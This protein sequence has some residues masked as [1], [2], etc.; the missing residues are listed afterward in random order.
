MV[1]DHLAGQEMEI[2]RFYLNQQNFLSS[3]NRFAVVVNQYQKTSHIEEALYRQVEIY[4][5]LGL[6][7]ESQDVF[8]V[9]AFNYPDSMWYKKASKLSK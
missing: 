9:L 4:K 5:L 6:N 1:Y 8:K 2:G 7:K 3:L